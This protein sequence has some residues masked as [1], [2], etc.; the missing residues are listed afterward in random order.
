MTA[1]IIITLLVS[2]V[3][4][5]L[6]LIEARNAR[7]DADYWEGKYAERDKIGVVRPVPNAKH[8]FGEWADGYTETYLIIKGFTQRAVF[9]EH[10]L[11]APLE[12][13]RREQE[14]K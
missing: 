1:G 6:A 4:V 9:T 13:A 7:K 14:T 5:G 3:F 2:A 10:E 11:K 12:R 8:E